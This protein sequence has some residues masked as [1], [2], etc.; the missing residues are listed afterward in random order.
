LISLAKSSTFVKGLSI[1]PWSAEASGA[2][3]ATIVAERA[4]ASTRVRTRWES[5]L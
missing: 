2:L 4:Q 5:V 3:I 1:A